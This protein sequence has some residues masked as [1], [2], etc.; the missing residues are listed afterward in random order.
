M[1]FAAK[2][3]SKAHGDYVHDRTRL[4]LYGKAITW[5]LGCTKRNGGLAFIFSTGLHLHFPLALGSASFI[6]RA[7]HK[8]SVG[9]LVSVAK[10]VWVGAARPISQAGSTTN[11]GRR[12]QLDVP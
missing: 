4:E 2:P 10:T 5:V 8:M 3:K 7:P 1:G 12:I 6:T 9:I 11:P